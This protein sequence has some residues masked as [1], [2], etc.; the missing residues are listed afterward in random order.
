MAKITQ[1]EQLR[2][3]EP[4]ES[5]PIPGRTS[6][7]RGLIIKTGLASLFLCAVVVPLSKKVIET[8]KNIVQASYSK[9]NLEQLYD[10]LSIAESNNELPENEL[11]M[12]RL[13][14]KYSTH[15]ITQIDR[16]D[17][18]RKNGIPCPEYM[19]ELGDYWFQRFEK[20]ISQFDE[21]VRRHKP[22][23]RS[24]LE[25]EKFPAAIEINPNQDS[26]RKV[27]YSDGSIRGEQVRGK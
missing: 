27:L 14:A 3:E 9:Y 1:N 11:D 22:G 2:Q 13:L 5:Q 20:P 8:R 23:Y 7:L 24:S 17:K 15:N 25:E 6:T 26:R 19:F 12:K 16:G 18:H 21:S 4:Q 10:I